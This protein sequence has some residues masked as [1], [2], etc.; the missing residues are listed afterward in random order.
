M[1]APDFIGGTCSLLICELAPAPA[2]SEV[3]QQSQT[4][5]DE[6][7]YPGDDGQAGHQASAEKYGKDGKQRHPGNFEAAWALRLAA[8]Q[9]DD[10]E[11]DQDE[12]EQRPDV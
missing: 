5:P 3:N 8:T 12:G 6:E 1:P 11:G 4:E 7:A 10:P 9:K 2:K